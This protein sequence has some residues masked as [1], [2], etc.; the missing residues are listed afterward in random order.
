MD[1]TDEKEVSI[2]TQKLQNKFDPDFYQLEEIYEL[3]N[4]HYVEDDG[5]MFRFS[6]SVSFLNWYIH[7]FT[8]DHK[9]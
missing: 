2:N 1:V 8:L 3:L 4:L 5:A 6:Y 7:Q 9:R